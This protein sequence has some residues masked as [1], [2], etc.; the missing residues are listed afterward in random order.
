MNSWSNDLLKQKLCSNFLQKLISHLMMTKHF[1]LIVLLIMCSCTVTK[2]VHRKGFNV[3]W[4]KNYI[5]QNSNKQERSSKQ[6]DIKLNHMEM[7]DEDVVDSIELV[8]ENVVVKSSDEHV[9]YS[10][11]MKDDNGRQSR[12]NVIEKDKRNITYLPLKIKPLLTFTVE[13]N[14]LNEAD[15]ADDL[16]AILG[17]I[18]LVLGVFLLLGCL[19]VFFGFPGLNGLFSTLVFS[20]NGLIAGIFGFLLFLLIVLLVILFVLLI[21]FVLGYLMGLILGATFMV[22]GIVLILIY[23]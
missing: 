15:E 17:F 7:L 23:S 3:E 16:M 6:D 21:Q 12:I 1:I 19:F 2:R 22:A 13:K 18:L 9:C 4:R 14:K 8:S 5:T 11:S 20:G 10:T